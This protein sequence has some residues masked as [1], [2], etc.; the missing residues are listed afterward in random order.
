M[1]KKSI[2]LTM[3]VMVLMISGCKRPKPAEEESVSDGHP[4][5][6]ETVVEKT[7][8]EAETKAEVRTS[9]S[10]NEAA[11]A[12]SEEIDSDVEDFTIELKNDEELEIN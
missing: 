12:E 8:T 9:P 1:I 4:A 6:T 7:Q 11:G 3:L 2:I 10:K 5:V